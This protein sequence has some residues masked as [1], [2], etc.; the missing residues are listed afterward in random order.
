VALDSLPTRTPDQTEWAFHLKVLETIQ[1]M[2]RLYPDDVF[3]ERRY[4]YAMYDRIERPKVIEEYKTRFAAHPH[5]PLAAY[6]YA[7]TLLGRQSAESTKLLNGALEDDPAFPW[8]HISL[9]MIYASPAFR[10]K[11][12]AHLHL[13]AFLDACPTSIEGYEYLS[14][15]S[16]EEGVIRKGATRL[17]GLLE[18]RDDLDAIEGYQTLWTLEYHATAPSEYDALRRQTAQDVARIRAFNLTTKRQWYDALE[19]GY[20]LAND[21]KNVTWA[22]DERE[23]NVPNAWVPASFAK[24]E[25]THPHPD[26]D[27]PEDVMSAYNR[28]FVEQ[29]KRWVQERPNT[30]FIWDMRL[31]VMSRLKEVSPAEI[32]EAADQLFQVASKNAGP[33]GPDAGEYFRIARVLGAKHLRPDHVL[34]MAQKGLTALEVEKDYNFDDLYTDE[35]RAAE[36]RFYNAYQQVEALA[37]MA[38]A[39][40]ELRQADNAQIKLS[41]MDERLEDLKTLFED[42]TDHKEMYLEQLSVYWGHMARLAE[43]KGRKLDAMGFY[44]NALLARLEARQKLRPGEKDELAD[45]AKKLWSS[46]GGTEEGWTMWYGRRAKDL[47]R[48]A[49]LR[50]DNANEPLPAFQLADLSGKTWNTESLKG[51]VT[52]LNFW[53]SW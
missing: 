29:A 38:G 44:E 50:W 25:E 6:L 45:D 2:R 39:Y 3:V 20:K 52:F 7:M 24:W 47:V 9:H 53:A 23:S 18:K 5:E 33:T 28:E 48:A 27:A 26:D 30:T 15:A 19:N 16:E 51:K 1:S 32:E 40:L 35:K 12:K 34:E 49:T 11:G 46:L 43:M 21:Q 37:I 8:A 10:D 14:R 36:M 22:K 31:D 41:Q 17:R 42:K 13:Q 4:I